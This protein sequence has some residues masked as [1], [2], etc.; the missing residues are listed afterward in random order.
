MYTEEVFHRWFKELAKM[1]I[2][3]D[4]PNLDKKS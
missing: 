3:P 2:I 4:Y 1:R